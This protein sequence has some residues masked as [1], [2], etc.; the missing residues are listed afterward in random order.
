MSHGVTEF[1]ALLLDQ[2]VTNAKFLENGE[3]SLGRKLETR[4]F[5]DD[6]PSALQAVIDHDQ[7]QGIAAVAALHCQ[8]I[9]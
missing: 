1:Q 8:G 7:A 4:F 5:N 9:G 2:A 3:Q 6:R